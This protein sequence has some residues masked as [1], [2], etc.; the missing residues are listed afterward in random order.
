MEQV[1]YQRELE[2]VG[3]FLAQQKAYRDAAIKMGRLIR[4]FEINSVRIKGAH[5]EQPVPG[6][7]ELVGCFT[8][9]RNILVDSAFREK[10]IHQLSR[11]KDC[12]LTVFRS[13]PRPRS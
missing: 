4:L 13:C 12:S 7:E 3:G 9:L 5:P 1:D 2:E 8:S 6:S 10:K 11:R